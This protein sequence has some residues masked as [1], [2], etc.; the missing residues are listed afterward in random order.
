MVRDVGKSQDLCK[1]K[2][3]NLHA[4]KSLSFRWLKVLDDVKLWELAKKNKRKS[5]VGWSNEVLSGLLSKPPSFPFID[6][7]ISYLSFFRVMSWF[8]MIKEK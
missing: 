8:L 3:V 6:G 1:K 4:E 2:K 7:F 5:K